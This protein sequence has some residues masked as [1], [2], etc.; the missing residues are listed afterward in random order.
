MAAG[1]DQNVTR[2]LLEFASEQHT[3]EIGGV[4][5]GG[6]PG[7]RATVLIGSTFYHGHTVLVD[8]DRGVL[9][10]DEAAR[11]IR[12]PSCSLLSRLRTSRSNWTLWTDS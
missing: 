11:R 2:G 7:A 12:T 10:R 8:E 5:V 9:D 4:R 3:V 1:L 6:S